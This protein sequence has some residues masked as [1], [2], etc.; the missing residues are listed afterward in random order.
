MK[1]RYLITGLLAAAFALVGCEDPDDLVIGGENVQTLTVKGWFVADE[2]KNDIKEYDSAIDE[3]AKVITIQAPYYVSDTEKIQGDLTQMKI[4]A[5]MPAGAKFEPGLSGIHDLTTGIQRTLVRVDGSRTNYTI[6]AA[7]VKSN[8]ASLTKATLTALPN[9]L[10]VISEP[11]TADGNGSILIYK[12]SSSVE[13]ALSSVALTV[14]PWATVESASPNGDGTFD[15]SA[16]PDVVVTA[17]DGTKRKYTTA[18]AYPS[19]VKPGEVGHIS[20]MFNFQTTQD[21]THGFVASQNRT[22][23]VVGDYLVVSSTSLNFIVMNRYS[24]ELLENVKVNTAGLMDGVI[25]AITNDDAGHMVAITFA[26]VNNKWVSNRVFEIYVWKNGIENA[27]EKVFSEDLIDSDKFAQFRSTNASVVTT[28]TWDIGRMVSVKGDVTGEAMLMTL[29][30]SVMNRL[31]RVKFENGRVASVLGSARGLNSWGNQS[32][33]IPLTLED[34]CDYLLQTSNQLRMFYSPKEGAPVAITQKGNWWTTGLISMAYTEF[35]GMKLLA[36][37]N[38]NGAPVQNARLVVGN[39]T[40][41]SAD[42]FKNSQIMDSRLDN[43]DPAFGPVG[44][45]GNNSSLS[46]MTSYYIQGGAT[47]GTNANGTGDVAFGKSDDGNAVQVYLLTTDHG[48]LAYEITRYN[49]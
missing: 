14:S 8:A 27:P 4:R 24:G 2:E 35:N 34:E 48:M 40:S 46:G 38:S 28:G 45:G 3:A 37:S 20:L 31:L 41:L 25:Q 18:L 7:Y 9:T 21:D 32:K 22:L 10:V 5:A 17:Q 12:T 26:A 13:L 23:A 42:S 11:T 6:K 15:L 44:P 36:V 1:I 19:F 16:F 33:P 30:N 39:I 49:I 47:V 43:Y 29:A